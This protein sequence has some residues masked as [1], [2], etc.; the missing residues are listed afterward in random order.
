ME[1]EGPILHEELLILPFP[2]FAFFST[3]YVREWAGR[4]DSASQLAHG[5]RWK[6]ESA[7]PARSLVKINKF[8]WEL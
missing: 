6:A 8:K 2:I 1:G 3:S 7:L 5:P 4:V